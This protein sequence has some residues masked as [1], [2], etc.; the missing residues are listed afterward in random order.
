MIVL[1]LFVLSSVMAEALIPLSSQLPLI[2]QI[3]KFY[4]W[5]FCNRTFGSDTGHLRYS[6]ST[7][8]S[9]LS[10]DPG[11]LT[12][13]GTPSA[14]DERNPKITVTASDLSTSVS[15]TFT[16][17]ITPFQ[18]PTLKHPISEQ[19]TLN[20]AALS[21][22]FPLAPNSAL[23]TSHPALRIPP[24]WSFSIG[25]DDETFSAETNI[26]YDVLQSDGSPLPDW[27]FFNSKA[28]TANGI[29]PN[30]DTVLSLAL[31]ASDQEGYTASTQAFDLVI[32]LHEMSMATPLP[33]INVTESTPFNV[34]LLSPA[35]FSGIL[36][37]G[38]PI[39]P[40][41]ITSLTIDVSGCDTMKYDTETRT[42]SGTLDKHDPSPGQNTR[43][44][45]TVT[46]YNQ[47]IKTNVSLAVVRSYFLS[48]SQAPIQ[49]IPG[50]PI[51]F[52][53]AQ[54]YSNATDHDVVE[55]TAAFEPVEDLEWLHFD[56]ET[57]RL[58]GDMPIKYAPPRITVHFTAYSHVT[59][60]T[61]HT[62]LLIIVMSVDRSRQGFRPGG[63]STAA[64][65]K[66]ILGLDIAFG[67]VGGLALVGGLLAAFRRCARVEDTATGGEEGR[68]VWS[69]Q[70]K[71]WYG[72]E[73]VRCL[74]L[75]RRSLISNPRPRF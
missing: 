65:K 25:F 39:R 66:L 6:T 44:P 55:L 72:L 11:A 48:S 17:C 13:S 10:F 63:L 22:V 58:T 27:I 3:D 43:F 30:E 50:R 38:Q 45:V 16:L 70:D 33:T 26:F 57:G 2:A 4:S 29:T 32:S 74:R 46:S 8:P 41:D 1:L 28:L 69:D 64:H 62:T 23:A 14:K 15:S 60:S 52:D 51:H 35:D 49:A 5:T 61:S 34:T 24:K 7:L 9:W 40:A 59:H 21:S 36:L 20:N 12:F 67:I 75:D 53:L 31:H 68:N 37:D 56:P 54:E 71:R 47:S 42:L 18:P 19:F 73:K